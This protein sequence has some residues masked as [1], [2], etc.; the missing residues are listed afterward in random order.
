[1]AGRMVDR[2]KQRVAL[3]L[4]MTVHGSHS[5]HFSILIFVAW[6]RVWPPPLPLLCQ[7]RARIRI[8]LGTQLCVC[9]NPPSTTTH[10]S[11]AVAADV[12]KRRYLQPIQ[13]HKTNGWE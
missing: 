13:A 7:W 10:P 9:T 1:M 5:I 3:F 12:P 11:I 4:Q 2:G 8:V 6:V